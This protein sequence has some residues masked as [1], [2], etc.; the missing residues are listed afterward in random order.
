MGDNLG[1]SWIAALL[2]TTIHERRSTSAGS[3]FIEVLVVAPLFF[4]G[5]FDTFISFQ[6]RKQLSINLSHAK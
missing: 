3:E 6:S 1:L 5:C 2:A 4:L